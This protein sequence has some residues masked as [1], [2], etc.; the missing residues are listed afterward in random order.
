[1]D[2]MGIGIWWFGG[3]VVRIPDIL[4][5]KGIGTGKGYP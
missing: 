1:M 2:P 3:P 4:L 5:M